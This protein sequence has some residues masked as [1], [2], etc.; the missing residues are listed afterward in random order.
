MNNK[1]REWIQRLGLCAVVVLAAGACLDLTVPNLNEPDR[2]RAITEPGDIEA[3]ISGGFRGWYDIETFFY[4]AM[5]MNVSADAASSSWGNFGMKDSGSEPRQA[6][7]NDPAYGSSAV[8]NAPWTYAYSSLAGVRDGMGALQ[9]AE[10]RKE[11]EDDLGPGQLE[12]IEV[13]GKLVQALSMAALAVIFDRAFIVDEDVEKIGEV[14]LSDYNAVWDA[15]EVKFDEVL[16]LSQGANWEIPS[17][18][19]GCNGPWNG[20]R[21]AEIARVY[22][23]RYASQVARTPEERADLDWAAIKA[24]AAPGLSSHYAGLYNDC[25]WAWH[26]T[27]WPVLINEGWGR[28]DYR[29]IGPSDASG[30]W[31][32]WINSE[33]CNDKKPFD[34]DTDDRRITGGAP[35]ID[36]EYI[37]YYGNSPFPADRG[38]CHYSHYKDYRFDHIWREDNF[39]AEWIAFV[40]KELDFLVAEANYRMGDMAGAMATVNRFRTDLGRLP[41]FTDAGGVAPGGNRCVPQNPDGSCGDLWEALKYEKRIEVYGYGFGTEYFDDRGWGD[42]V[43]DTWE[44]LPI[45]GSELETLLMD[46]YTFGGPGGNSSAAYIG[47]PNDFKKLIS[48]V[49]PESLRLKRK[50]LEAWRELYRTTPDDIPINK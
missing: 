13:F 7:N 24:D 20:A 1:I 44:Q 46:I 2:D 11:F 25:D 43:K 21:T 29:T 5:A 8:N 39:L 9:K 34:I 12:R 45:P 27:K 48:E 41:A 18:W 6:Y 40:P 36:G 42:L 23:A 30:N 35:N 19:V 10:T 15:A 4:P 26:G 22:R 47:A 37:A 3:L 16:Q 17:G 14:E 28:T 50:L 33:T 38:I 31:E 32:R 49:T